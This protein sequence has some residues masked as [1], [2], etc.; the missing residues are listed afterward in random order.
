VAALGLFWTKSVRADLFACF[1]EERTG[2]VPVEVALA[3]IRVALN[4]IDPDRSRLAPEARLRVATAARSLT[5]RLDALTS[6]LLAEADASH[7]SERATG[8]PTSTWLAIDQ[9]LTKREAA[10]AL[11]RATELA[12]HPVLGQAA[13]AGK[14]STGQVR[15]INTVLAGLAPQLD[16][17][18]QAQ[19][20]QLLE[21]G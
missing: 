19:A 18:Q 4:S 11:H 14:V 6:Q 9:N 5:G 21:H 8:T 1:M 12:A 13:V 2:L 15:A 20:E 17:G 10:G 16:S 3:R 7:A